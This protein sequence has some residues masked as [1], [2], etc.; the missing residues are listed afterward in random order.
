MESDGTLTT[1]DRPI[2]SINA[3]LELAG[4]YFDS[5]GA[6]H[7][8]VGSTH[9]DVMEAGSGRGQGTFLCPG[10]CLNDKG[11]STGHYIDANNV[12]H[13][14]LRKADGTIKTFFDGPGESAWSARINNN[15]QTCGFSFDANNATHAF[16]RHPHPEGAITSFDVKGAGT[17]SGQGTSSTASTILAWP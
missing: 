17:G 4:F 5:N 15:G 11:D 9:F 16:I 10:N 7:A 2:T 12:P 14:F 8:Y 13:G 1:R 3:S 6:A